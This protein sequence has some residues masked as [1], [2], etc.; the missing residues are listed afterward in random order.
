HFTSGIRE[1][2]NAVFIKEQNEFL[3]RHAVDKF[4][5]LL[6]G[7]SKDRAMLVYLDNAKNNERQPNENYARELMELF[8]LGVGNYTENDVKAAARALTGWTFDRD[9]FVFRRRDHDYKPKVFLGRTG[10]FDGED[11]IDIILDQPACSRHI[12]R[13]ILLFFVKSEPE[14]HLID[15]FAAEI[16][17]HKFDIRESMRTLFKS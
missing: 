11:I 5:E 8:T 3:R 9:G 12:A 1:V 15:A 4:R 13:K 10:K 2:K 14:K 7:I 16:R 17:K 6:V